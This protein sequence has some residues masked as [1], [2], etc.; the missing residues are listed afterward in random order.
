MAGDDPGSKVDKA[1]SYGVRVVDEAGL[2][3]LVRERGADWP[4][5]EAS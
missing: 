1:A 4:A 5:P 2:A 3:E